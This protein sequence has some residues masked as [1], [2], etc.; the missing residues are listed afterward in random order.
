MF[1]FVYPII[2]SCKPLAKPI[3]RCASTEATNPF[4]SIFNG[5]IPRIELILETV[6]EEQNYDAYATIISSNGDS[7]VDGFL[8]TFEILLDFL[9]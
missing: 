2:K 7:L 8:E 4:K 1:R 6:L 3:I 5:W 9:M